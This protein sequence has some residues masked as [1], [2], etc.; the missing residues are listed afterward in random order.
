MTRKH[1]VAVL[2]VAPSWA[3]AVFAPSAASKTTR[4]AGDDPNNANLTY[5][6]WAESD[7]PGANN[8]LKNEV[9]IYEKAHPK[10]KIT[11][12]LQST[13]TL[14]SAFTTAV[15]DEERPGHRDAVG[16]AA[17]ADAGVERR[18]GADLR[19]RPDERDRRTGSARRRTCGGKLWAMPQYLIGIPFVWNKTLFKKAGLDPNKGPKTWADFLADAQE[20]EG[21]RHHAVR[22][23]QQGRLR[24]RL[25]LLA[26]RQAEP[27]LDQRA[28]GRDDRQGRT[29]PIRSSPASTRRSP[30]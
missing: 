12:V 3:A 6:Y 2:G 14:T 18:V 1:V 21:G 10:V 15:A 8:W 22:H 30:I 16:D 11:V 27:Q 23:G 29:S 24:R 9:A 13:D 20:A 4:S 26:D 5:W 25:V 28:Q 17:D 19:L 7:A